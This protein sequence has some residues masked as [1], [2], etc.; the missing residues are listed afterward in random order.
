MPDML[1]VAALELSH[2]VLLIVL[3]EADN[4]ALHGCSLVVERTKLSGES[5]QDS[6][7]RSPLTRP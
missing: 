6:D 2:P 3:I 4:A 5:L 7:V 1:V